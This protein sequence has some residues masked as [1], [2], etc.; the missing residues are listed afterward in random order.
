MTATFSMLELVS[1]L[2]ANDKALRARKSDYLRARSEARRLLQP[3][4]LLKNVAGADDVRDVTEAELV[5]MIEWAH[6]LPFFGEINAYDQ[7]TLLRRS[8][9]HHILLEHC[10]YTAQHQ[11]D[12]LLFY[13][14]G[15]FMPRRMALLPDEVKRTIPAD[16]RWRQDQLYAKSTAQ[17][18][19]QV[20]VP[21]RRLRLAP[22]ELL[23]LKVLLLLSGAD[24]PGVLSKETKRKLLDWRSRTIS[25]LFQFYASKN[26]R[27]PEERFGNLL[28]SLSG[29]AAS[30]TGALECYQMLRLFKIVSFDQMAEKLVFDATSD[31]SD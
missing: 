17:C 11:V 18:I 6:S 23:L 21:L 20:V 26:Q 5:T 9:V 2:T 31:S 15:S 12:D 10:F 28:L 3:S 25:S 29:I 4:K 24:Q 22:E 30:A 27:N 16:R 8:A 7:Q 14:N 13:T 1:E 19:D